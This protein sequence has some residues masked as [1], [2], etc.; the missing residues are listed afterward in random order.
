LIIRKKYSV[1]ASPYFLIAQVSLVAISAVAMKVGWTTQSPIKKTIA[2][3]TTPASTALVAKAKG[4]AMRRA[5]PLTSSSTIAAKP[6][7]P[8]EAQL[9]A[10]REALYPTTSLSAPARPG[11]G[12]HFSASEVI[13]T[14]RVAIEASPSLSLT[15]PEAP[16]SDR[17]TDM[18]AYNIEADA[19]TQ[20]NL[21][22][23][24]VVFTGNVHLKSKRFA[25]IADR[26]TVYMN[27]AQSTLRNLVASGHVDVQ[28]AAARPEEAYRG[29]SQE[30]SYNPKDFSITLTGWPIIVG[31]A[32]EHR[33]TSP[34]THMVLYTDKPRLITQGRASTRITGSAETSKQAAMRS[35]GL[36]SIAERGDKR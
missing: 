18:A 24:T 17:P 20:M 26:L 32:R 13:E 30:A 5:P 6:S 31:S 4:P 19:A 36:G 28:I 10:S 34:S 22:T 16:L 9:P 23:Q 21:G 27:P 33:A 8:P 29:T 2:V 25:L 1:P 11:L 12:S 7:A 35:S 14:A 3:P 15:L